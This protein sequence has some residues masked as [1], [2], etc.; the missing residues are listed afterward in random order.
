M[1][2]HRRAFQKTLIDQPLMRAVVADLAL[3]YEAAA[4][5]TMRVARAFDGESEAGARASPAWRGARQ[6]LDHEAHAAVR[7]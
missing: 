3:D 1:S 5:L 4:M 6:V 2:S 7:L